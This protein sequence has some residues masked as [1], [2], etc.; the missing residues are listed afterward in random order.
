MLC[1]KNYLLYFQCG[2]QE[3]PKANHSQLIERAEIAQ[4]VRSRMQSLGELVRGRMQSLGEP[5]RSRM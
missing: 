4:L 5:V 3:D 1:D 2:Q